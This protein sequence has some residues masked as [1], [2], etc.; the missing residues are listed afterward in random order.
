MMPAGE[1]DY[2]FWGGSSLP[3]PPY[4]CSGARLAS[5]CCQ[6]NAASIQDL[7][8][9]TLNAA[10]S[11]GRFRSL[12]GPGV[13]V[14]AVAIDA[15]GSLTPPFSGWGTMSETDVGFWLLVTDTA[16]PLSAFWFPV[17]LYVDNWIALAGGREVWGFPKILATIKAPGG[18]TA[19]PI[20][21]S[22]FA[23]KTLTPGASAATAEIFRITPEAAVQA[24]AAGAGGVLAMV[25]ALV[26]KPALP[27]WA[28][29]ILTS[30]AI[31]LDT[32]AGAFSSEGGMIFLKQV[33]DPGSPT[34]ASYRAVVAARAALSGLPRGF[35]FLGGG[36]RLSLADYASQP[37]A[38]DL[39][40]PLGDQ[41]L[42][43]LFWAE[44]DLIIELGTPIG[45]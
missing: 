37:I 19:G 41:P 36:Y 16:A 4:S 34:A 39:G 23:M 14:N 24:D 38:S 9:R 10:T 32:A 45:D 22:T 3:G 43:P 11:P 29:P 35:G 40:L 30:L 18:V 26:A 17:Y 6:G 28:T 5:F 13:I 8:E 31:A 33:R 7:V 2:L 15:V 21:V 25:R 20:S 27:A 42:F 12:L 44:A 1:P